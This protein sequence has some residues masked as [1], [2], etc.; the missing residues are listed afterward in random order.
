MLLMAEKN[1]LHNEMLNLSPQDV[2]NRVKYDL[3]EKIA[4]AMIGKGLVKFEIKGRVTYSFG[5]IASVKGSVRVYHP[6]D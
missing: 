2:L 1:L 3:A 5:E 6:D 4:E